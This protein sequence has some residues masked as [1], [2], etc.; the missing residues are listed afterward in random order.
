MTDVVCA[1]IISVGKILAVRHGVKS[2]HALRW[3]FPGG[4]INPGESETDAL[5]REIDEELGI[6]IT[7]LLRLEEVVYSYPS[8]IIR[9][10][11]FLCHADTSEIV[12]NEHEEM[13]WLIPEEILQMDLLEA[14][15]KILQNEMNFNRLLNSSGKDL[16]KSSESCPPPYNG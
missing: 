14:D 1:I 12:L 3:E 9:L 8:K 11:P 15:R 16:Q 5:V 13:R 6:I 2:D 7:P 4:K 10:I